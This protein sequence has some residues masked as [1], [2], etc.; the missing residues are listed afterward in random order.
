MPGLAPIS[1]DI[2]KDGKLPRWECEGY[3]QSIA[4]TGS[5]TPIRNWLATTCQRTALATQTHRGVLLG[6]Q[7][8]HHSH[9]L[10]YSSKEPK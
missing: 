1:H 8:A 5:K 10:L 3:K 9:P 6:G 4:K 2:A 7:C